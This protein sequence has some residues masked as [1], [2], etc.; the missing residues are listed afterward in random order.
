M[1]KKAEPIK[2]QIKE[3]KLEEITL[4]H[5]SFEDQPL[6]PECELSTRVRLTVPLNQEQE[7]SKK[8]IVKKKKMIKKKEKRTDSFLSV[9]FSFFFIIFFFF[10]IFFLLSSCSWFKG[11]VNLT[12]VDNSHSGSN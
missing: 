11:T 2:R 12:R 5:H 7:E 8:K 3:T 10:T 6:E 1:V 9:L 4:K